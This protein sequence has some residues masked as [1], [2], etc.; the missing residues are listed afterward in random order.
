MRLRDV[1][2]PIYEDEIELFVDGPYNLALAQ[3][4]GPWIG[5]GNQRVIDLKLPVGGAA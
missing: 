4:V 2:G 1:L 3:S 5:S